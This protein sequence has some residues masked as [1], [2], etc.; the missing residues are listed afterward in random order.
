[1]WVSTYPHPSR[2]Q[3]LAAVLLLVSV[4]LF[5]VSALGKGAIGEFELLPLGLAFF[6][7]SFLVGPVRDRIK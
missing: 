5:V 1:M 6:A 4:V 7:A 2:R 3:G